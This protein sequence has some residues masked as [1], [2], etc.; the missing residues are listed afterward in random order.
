MNINK[1]ANLVPAAIIAT[2]LWCILPANGLER[3]EIPYAAKS[4]DTAAYRNGFILDVVGDLVCV[5]DL[6]AGKLI[7]ASGSAPGAPEI[8]PFPDSLLSVCLAGN[9]LLALTRS[10]IMRF[11]GVSGFVASLKGKDFAGRHVVALPDAGLGGNRNEFRL[12]V[13]RKGNYAVW[14]T[15]RYRLA[16]YDPAGK[17]VCSHPCPSRPSFTTRD[18]FLTVV[19]TPESGSK[20]MEIAYEKAV[21][22]S[23]QIENDTLFLDVRGNRRFTISY[24]NASDTSFAGVLK[25]DGELTEAS[26]VLYVRVASDSLIEKIADLPS[27][28]CPDEVRVGSGAF[29]FIQPHFGRQTSE[30]GKG[31]VCIDKL[32]LSTVALDR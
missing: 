20:I 29:F 7:I 22:D 24:Y 5:Q 26:P 10:G 13:D 27:G 19:F 2:L 1:T 30:A 18:S 11:S 9:D 12:Y 3:M 25:P 4:G 17:L 8:I 15:S 32:I 23:R 28:Y 6:V 16:I 31:G 21:K 14:N